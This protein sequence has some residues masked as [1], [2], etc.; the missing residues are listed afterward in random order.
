MRV[1]L[2][3]TK[4]WHYTTWPG[5]EGI[6]TNH[7]LRLSHARYLNDA[8]ELEI[9]LELLREV[10]STSGL[11]E[12]IRPILLKGAEQDHINDC[13]VASFSTKEDDLSQWRA[14]GRGAPPFAIRFDPVRIAETAAG[15]HRFRKCICDPAEQRAKIEAL[16]SKW[17]ADWKKLVA[18]R[19]PTAEEVASRCAHW[20]RAWFLF[21]PEIK[22]PSF[23][24]EDE[25]R[26]IRFE[27]ERPENWGF[28]SSPTLI[29]PHLTLELREPALSPIREVMIGPGPHLDLMHTSIENFLASKA[30]RAR[31]TQTQIPYR[32]W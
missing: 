12:A 31:V 16:V 30:I 25:W 11:P 21:A 32:N 28:H 15:L 22:D 7:A 24:A 18:A 17:I 14:S 10:I 29:V 1:P 2:P 4:L 5:L 26:V 19:A 20:T 27:K 23:I 6:I 8:R 9:A 3:D 13:F